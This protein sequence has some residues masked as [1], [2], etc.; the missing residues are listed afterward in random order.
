MG[1]RCP[2]AVVEPVRAVCEE[3]GCFPPAPPHAAS[4][5][6][7]YPPLGVSSVVAGR[8]FHIRRGCGDS[9]YYCTEVGATFGCDGEAPAE[10]PEL[11]EHSSAAAEVLKASPGLWGSLRCRRTELGT[12]FA[13]CIKPG[14][15]C[16]GHPA[17]AAPGLCAGDEYCYDVFRELFDG[18]I[19]AKCRGFDPATMRHP[20]GTAVRLTAADVDASAGHSVGVKVTCR[21]N[22]SGR[23]FASVASFEDRREVEAILADVLQGLGGQLAGRYLPLKGSRSRGGDGMEDGSV[24]ELSRLGVLFREPEH[25]TALSAGFGRHWPDGR[26]VFH[27][28]SKDLFVCVNQEE[29]LKIV[30]QSFGARRTQTA[31]QVAARCLQACAEIERA[32]KEKTG[33]GY[34]SNDRLGW[35]VSDPVGA[36]A[37]FSCC[38]SL[39][40]PLLSARRGWKGLLS[41]LQLQGRSPNQSESRAVGV[42]EVS[43]ARTLGST[44]VELHNVVMEGCAK[45]VEWEKMLEAGE[46]DRVDKDVAGVVG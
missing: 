30:S 16:K 6:F 44:T 5:D 20:R 37:A 26:G 31:G 28:W 2:G 36:G 33:V 7:G 43:N 15:D 3:I 35:V 12:T 9:P 8:A 41:A 29:H 11:S 1:A 17:I 42:W 39:N 40:L 19:A 21:R 25:Q 38:V 34:A 14:M 10:M 46:E 13:D 22:L 4:H 45:L 23:R 18:V 27:S 24:A 32:L